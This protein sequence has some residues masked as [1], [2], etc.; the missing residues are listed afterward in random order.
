V[1]DNFH[2]PLQSNF[3]SPDLSLS[4]W[5]VWFHHACV[6]QS[7]DG[8]AVLTFDQ[9]SA[10]AHRYAATHLPQLYRPRLGEMLDSFTAPLSI[11]PL[12]FHAITD[13]SIPPEQAYREIPAWKLLE[14][15]AEPDAVADTAAVLANLAN[16]TA[17]ITAGGYPA[18]GLSP[19]D[20][21]AGYVENFLPPQAMR[22][23]YSRDPELRYR[24]MT[25]GEHL[26][27]VFHHFL[28][29]RF[30]VPVPD[31]LMVGLAAVVGKL[32]AMRLQNRAWSSS[33]RQLSLRSPSLLYLVGGTLAYG[34]I[35]FQLYISAAILLP[36]L[37]PAI[38]V[39]AYV[40]PRLRRQASR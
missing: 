6:E 39:W 15:A 17:L 32:V 22:Y 14:P 5:L 34:L 16:Q 1:G 35:S 36:I 30:V 9:Q 33:T 25:G 13:F 24:R 8:C 27:Y 12:W 19:N 10:L 26:G 40:L 38:T 28:N 11:Y 20:N 29:R 23:W 7:T 37:L 4:Y 21:G 31:L 2:L 18:A 3:G